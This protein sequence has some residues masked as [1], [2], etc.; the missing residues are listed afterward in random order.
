MRVLMEHWREPCAD[1]ASSFHQQQAQFYLTAHVMESQPGYVNSAAGVHVGDRTYVV[2]DVVL[3]SRERVDIVGKVN[4][5]AAPD[6][7][8]DI[9]SPGTRRQDAITKRA[10]YARIGV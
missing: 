1:M 10:L 5:E 7:V 6:L 3:I 4:V 8:C 2:P 9:L